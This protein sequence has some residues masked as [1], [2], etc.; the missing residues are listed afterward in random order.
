M[1]IL[2]TAFTPFGSFSENNSAKTM[3]LLP[4]EGIKKLLLPTSYE[5]S[6][7]ELKKQLE[8]SPAAAVVMLGQAPRDKITVERVAINVADCS[9]ADNDG[10]VLTDSP[11]VEGGD[12]AYFS[13]L[14]IKE[15]L[16]AAD[17]RISNTAGTYVCNALFYKTAHY[18]HGSGIPC[19]F[20]HIPQEG[21]PLEYAAELVKMLRVIDKNIKQIF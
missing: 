11:L 17:C 10:A 15:M 9:M 6:F 19:G 20:I 14:P 13:T 4:D 21:S 2:V 7:S 12:A 5:R 8:T 3:E 18:L 1:D 16:K